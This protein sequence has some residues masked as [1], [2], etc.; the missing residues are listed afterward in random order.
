M[1][2]LKS[3][4]A[5]RAAAKALVQRIKSHNLRGPFTARDVHQKGWANLSDRNQ[6]AEGLSLLEELNWVRKHTDTETGG[7]PK[8]VYTVNPM[9]L[10]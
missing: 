1:N 8:E 3:G 2:G 10:P 5:A 4:W 7:R 6:V 9:V